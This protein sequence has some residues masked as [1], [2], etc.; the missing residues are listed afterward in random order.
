[1]GVSRF[2]V[3]AKLKLHHCGS[4]HCFYIEVEKTDPAVLSLVEHSQI[5]SPSSWWHALPFQCY[6]GFDSWIVH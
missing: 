2:P 4:I 5:G 1:M 3:Y 6:Y